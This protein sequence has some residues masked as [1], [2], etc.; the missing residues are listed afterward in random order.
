MGIKV[1]QVRE[2]ESIFSDHFYCEHNYNI[3]VAALFTASF[4]ALATSLV[5][6]FVQASVSSRASSV[7]T[8]RTAASTCSLT[9]TAAATMGPGPPTPPAQMILTAVTKF[10]IL[11]MAATEAA[12][13][14]KTT[15]DFP[16]IMDFLLTMDF[17]LIM[18]FPQTMD[19]PQTMDFPQTMAHLFPVP[20]AIPAT[21]AADFPKVARP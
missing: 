12:D 21:L 16:H 14:Y 10:R 6:A 13:S 9:T 3:A 2:I 5:T 1:S 4:T 19:S 15:M 17:P 8:T 20:T 18:D 11:D 7:N